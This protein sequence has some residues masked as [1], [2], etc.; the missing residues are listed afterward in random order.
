ITLLKYKIKP[1]T[2]D[3]I[4]ARKLEGGEIG[5]CNVAF[6]RALILDSYETSPTTGRFVLSD[7]ASGR[8]LSIGLI[9]FGLRRATN[10]HMPAAH[11]PAHS[12]T[13]FREEIAGRDACGRAKPDYRSTEADSI[14]K[15]T[16]VVPALLDGKSRHGMLSKTA[17]TNPQTMSAM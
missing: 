14:S 10:I 5:L 2:V 1:G 6:D 13:T 7:T 17:D 15:H 12:A 9:A 11:Q 16:P 3:A 8:R 4:A